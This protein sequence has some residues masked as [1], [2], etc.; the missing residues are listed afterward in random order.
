MKTLFAVLFVI[1]S[2]S[3][4]AQDVILSKE[5]NN[6][7]EDTFNQSYRLNRASKNESG[8][9]IEALSGGNLFV[10]NADL[11]G[12]ILDKESVLTLDDETLSMLNKQ[13]PD[14]KIEDIRNT[15]KGTQLEVICNGTRIA[16]NISNTVKPSET[17]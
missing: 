6:K 16:I 8:F 7:L 5:L 12:N 9:Y 14:F 13:C 11:K 10:I 4:N 2:S 3:L 15:E 1:L 17:K